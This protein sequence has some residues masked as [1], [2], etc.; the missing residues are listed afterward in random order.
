[1]T[2]IALDETCTPAW[3]AYNAMFES[4]QQHYEFLQVLENKQKKFNISPSDSDKQKL[5]GLLQQHDVKVREFTR[6]TMELKTRHPDSHKILFDFIG[7]LGDGEPN[8]KTQH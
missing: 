1:M 4:K 6:L 5:D 3:E 2:E 7:Q 8:K